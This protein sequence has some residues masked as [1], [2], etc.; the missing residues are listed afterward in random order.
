M[1]DITT[2][3]KSGEL[4]TT[5]HDLPIIWNGHA[6]QGA[7]LTPPHDDN[8]CLWTFCAQHDVPADTAQTG[9]ISEITCLPCLKACEKYYDGM[10]DADL[11]SG[12][13][14]PIPNK[15]MRLLTEVRAAVVPFT[16]TDGAA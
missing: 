9:E 14:S 13:L 7:N 11:P 3:R 5:L 16:K 1:S 10:A 8:F 6:C 2:H 4:C 12:A 15:A